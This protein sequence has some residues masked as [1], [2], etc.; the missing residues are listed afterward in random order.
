MG[1]K[2]TLV[3]LP[4]GN[5][6]DISLRAI[7]TLRE[8][9][10]VIC[11]DT[12]MFYKLW[13]KLVNDGHLQTSF[14][15]RLMVVNDFNEAEKVAW[16]IDQITLA[17][18]AILVSDAG[19]PL[20]SDPGYRIVKEILAREGTVEVIPGPTAAMTALSVSGLSAD[21][22]LFLGFL[23]KKTGKR[24]ENWKLVK[25]ADGITVI[26]YEAPVRVQKTLEEIQ[27]GFGP[28]TPVVIARE[29]TKEYEQII[30]GKISDVLANL[31]P[32]KGEVVI[33]FRR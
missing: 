4:L 9:K 15:G 25:E 26:L 33:L 30:R 5:I 10:T 29:L 11:E 13:Q 32:I 21:K 6:E 8:A 31:K 7:R 1:M 22:V 27:A 18:E 17:G 28:E 16:L 2:L 24:N 23:S 19:M 12:R 14:S 20:I 3:G